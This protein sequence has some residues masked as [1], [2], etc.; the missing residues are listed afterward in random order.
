MPAEKPSAPEE[1][2]IYYRIDPAR[3]AYL[4]YYILAVIF[5]VLSIWGSSFFGSILL[6]VGVV[7]FILIVTLVEF[8]RRFSITLYI[9]A[10]GITKEIGILNKE[11][12]EI[13]YEKILRTK[14]KQRFLDRILN[15]GDF[16]IDVAGMAEAEM[17]FEHIS[18]PMKYK[19]IIDKLIEE[20]GKSSQP[21]QRGRNTPVR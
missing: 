21:S 2:K 10:D 5:L 9:K 6:I 14:V 7:I 1:S 3:T 15:T 16:E 18:K 11:Y 8:L 20:K 17:Q 4:K 12:T 19:K 13:D